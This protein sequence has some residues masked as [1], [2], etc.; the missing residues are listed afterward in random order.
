LKAINSSKGEFVK[1]SRPGD[2]SLPGLTMLA[3]L[4]ALPTWAMFPE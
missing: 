4:Y 2:M 1:N 3:S